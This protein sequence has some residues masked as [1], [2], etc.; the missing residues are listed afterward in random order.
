MED[1]KVLYAKLIDE[2]RLYNPNS[3]FDLINKAYNIAL[4]G[5]MEQKRASGEPYIIHCIEVARIVASLELNS[6]SIAAALLHDVIEDTRFTAND[7]KE[8]FGSEIALIVEGVSKLTNIPLQSQKEQ[9]V[10]NIRKMFMAMS[11]DI[12][13][14]IVKL[15]DRLH[16]MRTLEY[17]TKKSQIEKSKETMDIYA[18]IAHRLGMSSFRIELED[19]AFMHLYPDDYSDLSQKMEKNKD[20]RY[21]LIDK[22]KN[23]LQIDL[24]NNKIEGHVEGR[25]KHLYSIYR[26]MVT[27]NKT[28][29]E[30]YDMFALRIIVNNI[31]DCYFALGM[32]HEN[33]KP[34][35]GRFKDY[36]AMPKKN[37]YQSLHTTLINKNGKPFEVQIRTW[38]MHR[39]AEFGIAAHWKYKQKI[40]DAEQSSSLEWI[41]QWMEWQKETK[42]EDEFYSNLK[43]DLFDMEVFVFTPKG[44]VINLPYGANPIDFAYH[45]HSAVGNKMIGAKVGGKMVPVT[46]TLQTGD[47]V[48]IVTSNT[49]KGPSRDW[50][51]LVKTSAART[52]IK[53]YFR[54]ERKEENVEKGKDQL[55]K[56]I[57]RQG[58][59]PVELLKPQYY[60][61]VLERY[62]FLELEDIM[63]AIGYGGITSNKII[64]KLKEEYRKDHKEEP[65]LIIPEI[66]DNLKTS[67]N[68]E[69][70]IVKDIPNCMVK[71]SKCCNP[72]PGD[73]IIGYVTRGRGVSVHRMDCINI[74]NDKDFEDRKIEVYWNLNSDESY[75][76]QLEIKSYDRPNLVTDIMKLLSEQKIKCNGVEAKL[77]KEGYADVRII[78]MMRNKD[79]I[80]ELNRKLRK[81]SGIF[82]ISRFSKRQK[83]R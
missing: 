42:D 79:E 49:S 51:K 27:Q 39:V 7:I 35:P 65:A 62:N 70:V 11:K 26:K 81:I 41:S 52:K 4:E 13:V 30:I 64:S 77:S 29:E 8:M 36:I 59:N 44:D 50:L 78:V 82:D 40:D 48:E 14:I 16:N 55:L 32:L 69:G 76:T 74:I 34:I 10:E 38:E 45:V 22:I 19:L 2:I 15:A 6:K 58:M 60:E 21:S 46:Y 25:V 67:K 83:L 75:E 43:N 20:E 66:A 31:K 71:I 5:H 56:E 47:I 54:K 28:L 37:M 73:D 33:Y 53:Q 23:E 12:R 63:C 72:V 18:P 9:Q 68:T 80:Q 61:K 17:K 24:N 1:Y 57:K 3:N